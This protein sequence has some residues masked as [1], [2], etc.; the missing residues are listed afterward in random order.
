MT[1]RAYGDERRGPVRPPLSISTFV[2]DDGGYTTVAIAVALLVSL[3]LV[4]ATA[5]ASWSAARAADV[6]E[7]ADATAMAGSNAVAGF[8]TIAQVSDACVVSLGLAGMATLGVGLVLSAIPG[9]QEAAV[10]VVDSGKKVL[11]MRRDFAHSAAEGLRNLERALPAIVMANAASCAAANSSQTI[12]Y[13]GTAIPF[14]LTS[15]TDYS[16]LDDGLSSEEL[17]ENAEELQE[18]S[19]RKREAMERANE[20]KERA[21]RADCVDDPLCM[22]SRAASL[23]GLGGMLNPNYASVAEWQ[24]SYAQIRSIN[25]YGARL[26]GEGPA[27]GSAAEMT[28]SAA[29]WRFYEYAQDVIASATCDESGEVPVID[30]PELPH[31]TDEMRQTSLYTDVVWPC[32]DEEQG[33]TLHSSLACPGAEGPDSGSASL[34]D[35]DAGWVQV[36]PVCDMDCAAQGSVASAST[37][38]NNGYEHYWRIVVEASRDYV[39]AKEDEAAAERDLERLGE[40]SKDLFQ[41]AMDLLSVDRPKVKP[42]GAWG[43]VAVVHRGG[44]VVQPSELVSAFSPGV[45]LPAGLAVSGAT[46]APESDTD[47]ST[48]LSQLFSGLRARTDF[49]PI[50]AVDGLCGLWGELLVSYGS[51]YEDASARMTGFLDTA[52]SLFGERAAAQLKKRIASVIE[53]TGFEPAD[54]RA[55]KPVLVHSQEVLDKAGDGR[56]AVGVAREVLQ[57]L[58]EDGVGAARTLAREAA[59]GL[60][61]GGSFTIAT[62]TIPGTSVQ[63]P[64]T[65]DVGALLGAA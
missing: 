58:P 34:A 48:V 38:I 60:G 61:G 25:Y 46:L 23:A 31:N 41:Q 5:A 24:F 36:C 53:A 1:G 28:R 33:R 47:G 39:K 50:G 12:S 14:P 15:Q 64:F 51:A 27:D 62:L 52:G 7:V 55:R 26:G 57:Q 17:E 42:A 2:R 30:L 45:E 9:A 3:T 18:A 21:W 49:G 63:I 6:Q 65:I 8:S 54:M 35:L 20:A 22:R 32:T 29:R 13:A 11:D 56:E 19:E 10:K 16:F 44:G 4:F 40:E 43:C 59:E 37:N